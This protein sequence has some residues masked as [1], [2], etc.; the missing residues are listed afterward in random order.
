MIIKNYDK[1]GSSKLRRNALDI[2]NSGLMAIDTSKVIEEKVKLEKDILFIENFKGK[3]KRY[4]LSKYK[5]IFVIG[6]G[7]ASSL[8]GK[9]IS[10]ILG[11][12]IN[13]GII[14]STKKIKLKNK[15]IKIVKGTHPLP[16]VT[17]LK[18]T[19]EMVSLLR[20]LDKEDLV[21]CLVSG[22]GSS[23][24]F[25]PKVGL[26]QYLKVM[27]KHF[28]SGI[29]IVKL[30]K[31]RKKLSNV[32][33]G[34]LARSTKAK[35]VS[36]IFSDVVGDDLSTIASGPTYTKG[37]DNILLLN[38]KVA[39][40]AMAK[41]AVALGYNPLIYSNKVKG[42]TRVVSKKILNHF[43]KIKNKKKCLLFGGE[44]TVSVKGKGRGGRNQEF[45]LSLIDKVKD[46]CVVSVG[47]DGIDGPTD[48]AGAI[49]E[50]ISLEKSIK[51]GL[52]F[53]KYL[54]ENDSYHFFKKM[55]DLVITGLTG[56]NVADVGVILR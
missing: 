7:K 4:D 55:D 25:Y 28:A 52:D 11:N 34:K 50:G 29:D 48:A 10:N 26:K 15:K 47:T 12:K 36:L 40:D 1:L 6:F 54:R 2:V 18:A 9:Y 3:I 51:L 46:C 27:D 8:M 24:L 20:S 33:D 30:N 14:I 16:S 53:K 37:V 35:V 45:C 44:T 17:N 41:K 5:R 43:N 38:N 56:S 42:E 19:K 39:L 13:S 49:V 21:I 23:L 22:G 31:I 32:K